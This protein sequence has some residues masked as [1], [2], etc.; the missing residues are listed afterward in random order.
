MNFVAR[1][2][3]SKPK[4]S[5]EHLH[6]YGGEEKNDLLPATN[7]HFLSNL[8]REPDL[9]QTPIWKTHERFSRKRLGKQERRW[10]TIRFI[11]FG[12]N[13]EALERLQHLD[14][15]L[16]GLDED[17]VDAKPW[18]VL[19]VEKI[20]LGSIKDD[21]DAADGLSPI[22]SPTAAESLNRKPTKRISQ[23]LNQR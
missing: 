6:I 18:H 12:Q 3:P 17:V 10:F 13:P 4:G 9:K 14:N 22:S 2:G 1:L 19:D 5:K 7:Q 11:S 8:A 21:A 15:N 23:F 20:I 16:R